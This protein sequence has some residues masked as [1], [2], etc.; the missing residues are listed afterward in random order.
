MQDISETATLGPP[1]LN[2]LFIEL[3]IMFDCMSPRHANL[4]QNWDSM[5]FRHCRST[6]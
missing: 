4:L 6:L 1:A 5:L 3:G 2:V